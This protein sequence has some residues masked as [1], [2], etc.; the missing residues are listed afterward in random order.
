MLAGVN[1]ENCDLNLK[2]YLDFIDWFVIVKESATHGEELNGRKLTVNLPFDSSY[3][4]QFQ[5]Q[6]D[7]RMNKIIFAVIIFYFY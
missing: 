5:D 4:L 1:K 6:C 2:P 3:I 7:L